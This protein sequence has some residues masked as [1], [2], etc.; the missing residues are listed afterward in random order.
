MDLA[1]GGLDAVGH[2]ALD[3]RLAAVHCINIVLQ[4]GLKIFV[5]ERYAM[6][7]ESVIGFGRNQHIAQ[8]RVMRSMTNVLSTMD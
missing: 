2:D 7:A 8:L 6:R 5:L 1:V 4:V 3:R